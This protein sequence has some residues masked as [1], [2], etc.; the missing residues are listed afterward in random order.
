MQGKMGRGRSGLTGQE[1]GPRGEWSVIK[2]GSNFSL[3]SGEGAGSGGW[4]RRLRACPSLLA[5]FFLLGALALPFLGPALQ[6]TG[7]LRG[8][9]W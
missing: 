7:D 1:M 3:R 8:P 5:L 4:A 6:E 9:W 2:C